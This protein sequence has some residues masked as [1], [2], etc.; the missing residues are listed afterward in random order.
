MRTPWKWLAL[1]C[2]SRAQGGSNQTI[3]ETRLSSTTSSLLSPQVRPRIW[4]K[5]SVFRQYLDSMTD[6]RVTC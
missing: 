1:L 4:D 6:M 5:Q 2:H 3:A